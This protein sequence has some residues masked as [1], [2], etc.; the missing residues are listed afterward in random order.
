M[1]PPK[2]LRT[3]TQLRVSRL[4]RL[5]GYQGNP[6]GFLLDHLQSGPV[7]GGY[8]HYCFRC[9]DIRILDTLTREKVVHRMPRP[10]NS[11]SDRIH[12][13]RRFDRRYDIALD[14]R[15]KLVRRR[16]VL[17][18]GIGRTLDLSSGGILFDAGRQLP[19]GL[20]IELA[21][22]WPALLQNVAPM[23]LVVSGRIIRTTGSRT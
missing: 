23:Q 9:V 8:R 7:P 6:Y 12:G 13:E 22:S 4:P 19:V 20:G 21:I 5:R 1:P 3:S 15:W 10:D 17:D 11:S 16:R 2:A 14:L 18:N